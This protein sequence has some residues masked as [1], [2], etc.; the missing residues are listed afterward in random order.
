LKKE[1]KA[2]YLLFTN[3]LKEKQEKFKECQCEKSE[4]VRVDYLDSAGSG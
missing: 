3:S 4:K 1:T 2:L